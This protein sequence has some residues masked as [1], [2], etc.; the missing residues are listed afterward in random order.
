MKAAAGPH[1]PRV[2]HATDKL[3]ELAPKS[4]LDLNR[5]YTTGH[6]AGGQLAL[7][8]ATRAR[9]SKRA[10]SSAK[11]RCR[12]AAFSASPQSPISRSTASAGEELPRI[13]RAVLGGTPETVAERYRDTSPI[14]RLP[15]GV[16]QCLSRRK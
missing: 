3:R 1:L 11:I 15:L 2:A 10:T 16:R 7:W 9:L 5:V 6:S 13:G 14:Q 12:F 4:R 8:L